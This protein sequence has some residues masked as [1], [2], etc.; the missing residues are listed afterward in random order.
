[1]VSLPGKNRDF[2]LKKMNSKYLKKIRNLNENQIFELIC[3]NFIGLIFIYASFHKISEPALFAKII[4]GYSL[5]PTH[6]I[7]I[8]AI[9]LPFAELFSGIFLVLGI[10]PRAGILMIN[11]ML[12]IF[13]TAITINLIRGHEFDCGCF[14]LNRNSHNSSSLALLIRDIFYFCVGLFI[15]RFNVK[16]K[17][18]LYDKSL[19]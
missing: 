11:L 14:S 17:F 10:Y 8:T 18:C 15:F 1:M 4:Y 6:L 9:V 12:L 7:N 13:I 3:R 19:K 2:Q 16:R 5:L